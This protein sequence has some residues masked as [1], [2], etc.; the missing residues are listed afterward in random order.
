MDGEIMSS[1]NSVS[2]VMEQLEASK[3]VGPSIIHKKYLYYRPKSRT[4]G[5]HGVFAERL[6]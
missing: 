1:L 5:L 3:Q 4:A 6:E 2:A